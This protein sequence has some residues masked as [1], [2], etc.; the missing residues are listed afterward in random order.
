MH[1]P[2]QGYLEDY[3][4]DPGDRNIP[5]EFHAH[6]ASCPACEGQVR[7]FRFQTDLLRT[8]RAPADVEPAPAF[9]ARVFSQIE[10][11]M[12]ESFWAAFLDPAF[13]KRLAFACGTL[14]VLMGTYLATSESG[15]Q[16]VS[17][18][19]PA[20]VVLTQDNGRFADDAV[21]PHQRDAVLAS[22]VTYQE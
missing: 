5:P 13:G 19:A 18:E 6:L 7:A 3:L 1:Q 17:H 8:L 14:V 10:E 4:R 15:G 9:Y 11:R 22:F 16:Y 12:P 21:Q 2:I 20:G